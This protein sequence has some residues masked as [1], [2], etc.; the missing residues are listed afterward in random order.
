MTL[1]GPI[2]HPVENQRPADPPET[3]QAPLET[4]PTSSFSSTNV[5]SA[6]YDFGQNELYVRYLR[7]GPDAIYRY[8][9]VGAQTWSG[10]VDAG[11]KGGYINRNI[12]YDFPYTLLTKGDFPQR[13]HGLDNDLARRFVTTP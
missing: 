9:S 10:L 1:R 7:D 13:G 8:W 4:M 6:L 3:I 11:S 12:A 5:H 2:D